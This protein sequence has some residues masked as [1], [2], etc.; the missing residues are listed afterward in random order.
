MSKGAPLAE[1]DCIFVDGPA[2]RQR[3]VMS[4]PASRQLVAG[5]PTS[6]VQA[7]QHPA[8]PAS[9]LS[10]TTHAYQ[11]MGETP[12]GTRIYVHTGPVRV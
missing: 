4:D 5:S 2:D 8:H 12:C 7:S 6:V 10:W 1:V 11:L 9:G 3:Q